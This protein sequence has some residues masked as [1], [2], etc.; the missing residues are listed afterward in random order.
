MLLGYKST[1]LYLY[2]PNGF[3]SPFS[4]VF[5]LRSTEFPSF[6]D[7]TLVKVKNKVLGPGEQLAV[8]FFSNSVG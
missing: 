4:L 6:L 3:T 1:A 2:R 7:W 8:F 5:K